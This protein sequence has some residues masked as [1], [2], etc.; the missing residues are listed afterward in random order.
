[1]N[2]HSFILVPFNSKNKNITL[3]NCTSF[4]NYINYGK[5]LGLLNSVG[6]YYLFI[7]NVNSTFNI[8]V[9][10]LP[11]S[12]YQVYEVGPYVIS[13]YLF[14]TEIELE[15]KIEFTGNLGNYEIT[16]VNEYN[17]SFIST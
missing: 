3:S 4:Y 7:D 11:T 14:G 5:C 2:N 12:L 15:V 6:D 16:L 8:S 10:T 9:L 1:M 13:D 17:K